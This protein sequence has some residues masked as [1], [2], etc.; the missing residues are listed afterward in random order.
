MH[1][2]HSTKENPAYSW[3]QPTAD[4]LEKFK[5]QVSC[6]AVVVTD[7]ALTAVNDRAFFYSW[8]QPTAVVLAKFKGQVRCRA[9]VVTG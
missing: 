3:W 8:W 9:V 4:V 5:G 6:R 1:S 7:W 2:L